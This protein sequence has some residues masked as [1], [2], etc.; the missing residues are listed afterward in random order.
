MHSS[1][2]A[3]VLSATL[4]RDSCW[5]IALPGLLDDLGQ[6]P[7]LGLRQWP[8]LDDAHC[9]ADS[10]RVGLVVR[11]ELRRAADDLLVLRMDLD[12]VDLDDDR[13]VALVRHHHAAALL[14]PAAL[15]LGNR[16]A[17][18][19]LPRRRG[20]ALRLRAHASLR[21]RPMA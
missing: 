18:D 17:D 10:G 3:P 15:A 5:I 8:R 9:V 13:L 11:V 19:R 6:A 20:L 21:A 12:Q 7:A 16:E 1:S 4:R 14:A 2:R